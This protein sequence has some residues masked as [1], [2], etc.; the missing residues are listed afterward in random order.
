MD[1]IAKVVM[2]VIAVVLLLML[3]KSTLSQIPT[4]QTKNKV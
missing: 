3:G 4:G 1:L 2:N